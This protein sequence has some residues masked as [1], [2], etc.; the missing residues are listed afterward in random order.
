[1][2]MRYATPPGDPPPWTGPVA[3]PSGGRRLLT[4]P[5][6]STIFGASGQSGVMDAIEIRVRRP[7]AGRR[8]KSISG[9]NKQNAVK[10]MVVTDA[11][12]RLLCC[13]PAESASCADI[14]DARQLALRSPPRTSPAG[15]SR[16]PS[17][18]CTTR[19]YVAVF[20]DDVVRRYQQFLDRRRGQRPRASTASRTRRNGRSSTSTSTSGASNSAPADALT[21]RPALTN[22][23]ASA[24]RCSASTRKWRPASTN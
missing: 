3:S 12:G 1:M 23:P 21:G 6:S 20:D 8:E 19:G 11:D 13:S 18:L 16:C 7:A 9:K 14:T 10:S 2:R 17:T 22:T 4:S 24:A 5:K 15:S